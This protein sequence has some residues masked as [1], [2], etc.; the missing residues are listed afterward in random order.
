MAIASNMGGGGRCLMSCVRLR[1]H[2]LSQSR[3]PEAADLLYPGLFLMVLDCRHR[4]ASPKK[5]VPLLCSHSRT[6]HLPHVSFELPRPCNSLFTSP[7]Y[8]FVTLEPLEE[9]K[10][11]KKV[12][13]MHAVPTF[14]SNNFNA[15]AY[16]KV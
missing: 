11:Y 14:P 9:I 13:D 15:S 4:G 3:W 2:W 12:L 5:A 7:S 16:H 6:L 10:I 1:Y 8:D